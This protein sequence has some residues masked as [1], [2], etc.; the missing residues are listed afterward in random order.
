MKIYKV[1]DY[2]RPFYI[3]DFKDFDHLIIAMSGYGQN[4]EWFGTMR[5]FE[6]NYNFS[7]LWIRDLLSSY[8]HGEFPGV[9]VG[10][11]VLAEFIKD[12]IKESGAKKVM[13]MGLSMGGYASILFG[14]L[15]N[16]DFVLSFSGQTYLPKHRRDKYRLEEKWSGLGV[17]RKYT[18]LKNVFKDYNDKNKTK[19]K[20]FYGKGM[21]MDRKFAEHLSGQRGVELH[22]VNSK[23]HNSAGSAFK[24]GKVGKIIR[25]FLE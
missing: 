11:F 22:P 19:Y 23:R 24:S 21:K 5:K 20:L 3:Q 25:E 6:K 1:E 16:L 10:P 12:K 9:G 2:D 7:K 18:D 15:C 13:I 4:Y 17:N 8:W 14:C